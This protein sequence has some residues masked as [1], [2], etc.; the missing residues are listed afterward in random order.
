METNTR[1]NF[2][3]G[4]LL[5]GAYLGTNPLDGIAAG[6]T[7]QPNIVV[8]FTDDMGF[9]DIGI[10]GCKDIPTPNID[11]LAKGGVHFTNGYVTAPQCFPSRQGLFTGQYQQRIGCSGN[12]YHGRSKPTTSMATILKQAGYTCGGLGKLQGAEGLKQLKGK[13]NPYELGRM[14]AA[15]I[16]E[17]KAKPFFLYYSPQSPHNPLRPKRE[18]LARF[19]NIKDE[20]RRKYAAVVFELDQAVGIMID[21]LRELGLL[22]NTL[23]FFI[24]DNGGPEMGGNG[25]NASENDPLKGRKTEL[26][27]GGIRVPFIASWKGTLPAGTIYRYPVI[28]TDVFATAVALAD[29]K[30]PNGFEPDGVNLIPYLK[31][32]NKE[33][34]HGALFWMNRHARDSWWAVR[35]GDNKLVVHNKQVMLF[36]LK[37]D[38]YEK[39]DLSKE[40]P[41]KVSDLSSALTKWLEQMPQEVPRWQPAR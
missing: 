9:G 28:T 21:K 40:Q 23:I 10:H 16:E 34:P 15:F 19:E 41:D 5:A 26:M 11:A 37:E 6:R 14:A 3:K 7:A 1:R 30:L 29:A 38:P 2:L 4:T 12:C 25:S 27:E 32:E 35:K 31:G 24:N 13:S 36:N 22:E 20:M 39:K 18:S 17:N 33:R 8:M